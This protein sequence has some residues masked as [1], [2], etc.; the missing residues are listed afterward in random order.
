MNC[1]PQLR[2]EKEKGLRKRTY[3][4]SEGAGGNWRIRKLDGRLGVS[5]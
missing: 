1:R 4:Q 3:R 5:Q 2:Q